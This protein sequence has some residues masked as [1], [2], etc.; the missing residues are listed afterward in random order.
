MSEIQ[1]AEVEILS[2]EKP[3]SHV[4]NTAIEEP[5]R[6]CYLCKES[7]KT[8][9]NISNTGIE[10]GPYMLLPKGEGSHFSCYVKEVVKTP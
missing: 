4:S 5:E 9:F 7:M 2:E 6:F 1:D 10:Q 3:V 8:T